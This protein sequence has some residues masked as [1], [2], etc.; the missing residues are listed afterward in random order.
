MQGKQTKSSLHDEVN[1]WFQDETAQAFWDQ[2][3]AL[4][5]RELL[6]DTIS[7]CQPAQNEYWLDLGC[8]GG[9]LT[10]SLWQASKGKV[11][12]IDA[13]DCAA[14]N[15]DAIH[16][17][18]KR[19]QPEPNQEQVGF[20]LVDFSKGLPHIK[21]ASYDGIVSG[22][23]I[24]YAESFDLQTQQFTDTAYTQLYHEMYRILKPGGR[25]VFS[26]NVP[27]PDFWKIVWKSM[28]KG[29][30]LGKP[31]R[32]IK[33]VLNMQRHGAWLK[34]EAARGRFHFLPLAGILQKLQQAGFVRWESKLSYADQAYV[35]RAW[36]P[37]AMMTSHVA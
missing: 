35:I 26:V 15:A 14:I 4:P 1:R 12:H 24:S 16:K 32:T 17:L 20:A 21:N 11:G 37:A 3:R 30:K 27:N 31:I 29:L 10:A 33:N 8:G 5:Y 18:S 6:V 7:W 23:A 9:H 2:H 22:L 25:L 19:L 28:G 13:A 34:R 36:K